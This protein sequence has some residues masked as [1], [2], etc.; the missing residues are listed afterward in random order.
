MLKSLE[1]KNYAIIEEVNLHFKDGLTVI[2]GETGAGK[3][4]LLG[5]LGLILGERADTSV[6]YN[7]E[8][9]CIVEGTFQVSQYQLQ[10]FFEQYD[11]DY[12]ETCSIRRE[13]NASGKSRAFI[14]DTPTTLDV[15]KQLSKSLVDLHQQFDS[16]D[17]N[18]EGKQLDIVDSIA[19]TIQDRKAYEEGYEEWKKMVQLRKKHEDQ[20]AK[21]N[22]ENDFNQFL[23][24]ELDLINLEPGELS[25]LERKTKLMEQSD[26]VIQSC[27][28][29]VHAVSENEH[30]IINNLTDLARPIS[31]SAEDISS[32]S[33]LNDKVAIAIELLHEIADEASSISDGIDMDPQSQKESAERLDVINRVLSKH[34]LST[35]EE[36]LL[37]HE[38]LS[39]TVADHSTLEEKIGQL[40]TKI[41]KAEKG[42]FAKA[43][44]LSTKRKGVLKKTEDAVVKILHTMS[45]D[46]AQLKIDLLQEEK[47]KPGGI[48]RIQFLFRANKGGDFK[49]MGKVASGGELSRLNLA[50]KSI[51]ADA[52]TMPTLI[53]DEIDTGISGNVSMKMGIILRKLSKKH[54][55]ICITHSPQI[56][57]KGNHHFAIFKEDT[58]NKT[59]TKVVEVSEKDIEKEIAKMLGGDPVTHEALENAR[60]LLNS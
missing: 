8:A 27:Q 24:K 39:D 17:I 28:A 9:K 35:E 2:T 15:L 32:L 36:L 56:A 48:D 10:D 45:M 38:K 13:I 52:V 7:K 58:K 31:S 54:Q 33:S 29:I 37:L 18:E 50:I 19:A 60:Q 1:I 59:I 30:S 11:L 5:A 41:D 26:E 23:L 57:S 43:K 12:E 6:L 47:L 34:R 46:N 25:E 16:R 22:Q 49:P 3:S 53:F 44:K 42:L 14:N 40:T 4:I 51:M 21:A 20:L 55:T